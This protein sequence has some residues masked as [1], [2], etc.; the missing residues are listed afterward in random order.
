MGSLPKSLTYQL[1]EGI[2]EVL[3]KELRDH[4]PIL[5]AYGSVVSRLYKHNAVCVGDL[6]SRQSIF[7]IS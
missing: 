6:F 3:E 7:S 5:H 1:A 4:F 2:A